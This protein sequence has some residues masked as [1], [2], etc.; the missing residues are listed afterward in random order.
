MDPRPKGIVV[1]EPL[2]EV[3]TEDM[4]WAKGEE[5]GV[6]HHCELGCIGD[7]RR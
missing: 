3:T 2:W 6:G 1:G 4:V 5:A 7:S